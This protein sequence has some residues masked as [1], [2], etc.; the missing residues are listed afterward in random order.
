MGRAALAV[1]TLVLVGWLA[2]LAQPIAPP[3]RSS[4]N[5]PGSPLSP[6]GAG[7]DPS[8]LSKPPEPTRAP[9]PDH[10]VK[11]DPRKA[12]LRYIDSQW[13]LVA[14]D[15]YLKQFGKEQRVAYDAL[16]ALRSLELTELASIGK[17]KPV[18]EYFL[19]RGRAPTG[20]ALGLRITK[21]DLERLE[22][23]QTLGGWK[24]M[25]NNRPLFNFGSERE[26]AEKALAII[27]HYQFNQIGHLGQPDPLMTVLLRDESRLPKRPPEQ[28][29][30]ASKP[31]DKMPGPEPIVK[32]PAPPAQTNLLTRVPFDCRQAQVR[33]VDKSWKIMVGSFALKDF[34]TNERDA[35]DALR[36]MQHYGFTEQ[37]VMEGDSRFEFFLARGQAPRGR[38][39]GQDA[40]S[41]RPDFL[42]VRQLDDAWWIAQGEQ[43]LLRFD[44]Q[45]QAKQALEMIR[46]HRFDHICSIGRPLPAMM[47]FIQTRN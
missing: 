32:P 24:L 43:Q 26:E 15:T 3:S 11:F 4:A 36:I 35:R 22:L 21:F 9:A 10:S 13:C 31:L 41:F 16:V 34:G 12:E 25:E 37:H 14:G 42:T 1:G 8:L 19:C 27:R 29:A 44:Q 7:H 45:E 18:F 47:Y 46:K 23:R 33:K 30:S 28:P 40:V 39:V 38:M 20:H 2:V 6:I 17:P 5:S